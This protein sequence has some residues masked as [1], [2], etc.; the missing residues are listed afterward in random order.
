MTLYETLF[1]VRPEDGGTL[2]EYID[3]YKKIIEELG[4]TVSQVEEWGMR[5]LAYRIQKQTRGY[6]TLL[7]YRSSARVV[8]E[9]ERN[10]KLSE[11]VLRYLSVR[12]DESAEAVPQPKQKEVAAGAGRSEGDVVK[13]EPQA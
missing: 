2:K 3:R 13:A 10:M 8:E 11:G 5:D 1:I 7:R 4:G 6:Y 9:L 12:S